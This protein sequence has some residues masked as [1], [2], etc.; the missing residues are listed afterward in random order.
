MKDYYSTWSKQNG[1]P[2]FEVSYTT[3]DCYIRKDLSE[4]YDLSSCSYH[5]S[6][7]LRNERLQKAMCDQINELPV[8]G[9]KAEYALKD[10]AT[11][12]LLDHMGLDSSGKI[13]YTTSGAESVENALKI[14]R[15]YSGKSHILSRK[16]SYHGA[17][18]GALSVTGDWRRDGQ[19][20]LG[21]LTHFIPE[22]FEKDALLKTEEVINAVGANKIAAII[23][24]TITGGNGVYIPDQAWWDGITALCKKYDIL[25]ILDEVI[26]GF[27]RTGKNFGYQ[28]FN[29]KP[30]IV[31]LAKAIS[32]GYF[33]FGAVY[34]NSKIAKYFDD[35]ILCAGLTNYAHPIGLKLCREII[36]YTTSIDFQNN[37]KQVIGVL[38]SFKSNFKSLAEVRDVRHIGGLMAIELH[39]VNVSWSSLIKENI[40]LNVIGNNLIICPIL[41]TNADKLR[42]VLEKL[43]TII[44]KQ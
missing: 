29:L 1:A 9:P 43:I 25:L 38:E 4:I 2:S 18:M 42:T 40:Y 39:T 33:P 27:S 5:L 30:D 34:T 10:E 32:G 19:E 16:K 11:R 24:E 37:L 28:H 23:L 35:K 20:I 21:E 7:G 17:T 14:A 26:C 12:L 36:L 41:T 8:A 31:C 13:F 44:A 15:N 6:F 22:P 3:N